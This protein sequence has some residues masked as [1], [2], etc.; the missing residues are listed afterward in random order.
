VF[1]F[2]PDKRQ[3]ELLEQKVVDSDLFKWSMDN[4]KKVISELPQPTSKRTPST[5]QQIS[6]GID[7]EIA[8]TTALLERSDRAHP[9]SSFIPSHERWRKERGLA[10]D[11][12]DLDELN[13]RLAYLKVR[14]EQ[15][16]STLLTTPF[17]PEKDFD[18]GC[19]GNAVNV[20]TLFASDVL[21][22]TVD[23]FDRLPDLCFDLLV[24]EEASQLRILKLLKVITK[25]VRGRRHQT[26]PKILL[27]G[28][29][30]QLPPFVDSFN[31]VK[32]DLFGYLDPILLG[33][34]V[35]LDHRRLLKLRRSETPF[36]SICNRHKERVAR[37]T[38][39]WRMRPNLARIVNELFYS[40]EK[41]IFPPKDK[42][43]DS[44]R[45]CWK[46]S[47]GE[48]DYRGTSS[49]NESE[50]EAVKS[51]IRS[52]ILGTDD[53]LVITPYAAQANIL[54]S[55]LPSIS[56]TTIDG[57]QGIQA[58]IVIVSFVR[59]DFSVKHDFVIEPRRMNV[60]LSRASEILCLV[61]NYQKLTQK[62]AEADPA[63]FPHLRGLVSIFWSSAPGVFFIE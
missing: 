33:A 9:L 7:Q 17:S 14:S 16:R 25:V 8:D 3:D 26:A 15:V 63:D 39:Q 35:H 41:W 12:S 18:R 32:P 53:V 38:T 29:A 21:V 59:F 51:I 47:V 36:D 22:T 27:S 4:I 57:C 11:F 37:L 40:D 46:N 42:E 2:V 1:R 10:S 45:I 6:T 5:L 24:I 19:L 43:V 58:P 48:H 52:R 62:L 28:D 44:G 54:R 30:Q 50:V 49:F 13:T 61:G 23:A 55:A 31:E 34:V 56:V 60:A 20:Y